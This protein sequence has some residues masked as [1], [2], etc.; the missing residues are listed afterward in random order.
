MSKIKKGMIELE[1]MKRINKEL[2]KIFQEQEH[3]LR[4]GNQPS[5]GQYPRPSSVASSTSLNFGPPTQQR[6]QI[7]HK[8]IGIGTS[9]NPQQQQQHHVPPPEPDK[10]MTYEQAMVYAHPALKDACKNS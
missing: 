1:E 5:I 6:P 3:I 9:P 7:V 10:L 4:Q 8:P 2:F